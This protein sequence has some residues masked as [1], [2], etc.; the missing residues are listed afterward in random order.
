MTAQTQAAVTP[1]T[2]SADD[3]RHIRV[4]YDDTST[5]Y[6]VLAELDA[7]RAVSAAL[8][9]ACRQILRAV[10]SDSAMDMDA[11]KSAVAKAEGAA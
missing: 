1:R 6:R 9:A 11:L 8:L 5:C 2:Y 3:E 10:E 7:E 4:A